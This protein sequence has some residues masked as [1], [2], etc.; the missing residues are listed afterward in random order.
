[1]ALF[2]L[3]AAA[4]A[5]GSCSDDETGETAEACTAVASCNLG[6]SAPSVGGEVA[7][8]CTEFTGSTWTADIAMAGCPSSVA[9]FI[10]G[11]CP[12]D[13]AIA[14]CILEKGAVNERV[15]YYFAQTGWTIAE[16]QQ[17]CLDASAQNNEFVVI[18]AS[19]T[20]TSTGPG[21]GGGPGGGTCA[22]VCDQIV[23]DCSSPLADCV[24]ECEQDEANADSCGE[25]AEWQTML[26]CCEAVGD[27]SAFCAES[28]FDPC[29][30]AACQDLRPPG[31]ANG[32]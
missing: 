27:F 15:D 2:V 21:G 30:S 25:S 24:A 14:K 17:I 23:A 32:C 12:K 28:G 6:G 3:L 16:A 8:L 7:G 10:E 19:A 29:Q 31:A 20:T 4:V 5:A 22:S 18:D 9:T 26:D 13:G 1:M 11:C